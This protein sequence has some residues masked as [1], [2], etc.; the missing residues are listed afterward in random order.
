MKIKKSNVHHI[1]ELNG[2]QKGILFDSL[3]HE[4]FS[5]YNTQIVLEINGVLKVGLFE[6]SLIKAQELNDVLRSVFDWEKTSK[7][8]QIILK[9]TTLDY[10]FISNSEVAD[11]CI[12]SFLD[13]DRKL[14][15][16]LNRSCPFRIRLIQRTKSNYLFIITHHTI[17]YDGWSNG[18]FL[19][20]I[21]STYYRLKNTKEAYVQASKIHYN[22]YIDKIKQELYKNSDQFWKKYLE[23]Y[24]PGIFSQSTPEGNEKETGQEKIKLPIDNLSDFCK[25]EQLT[26]ASLIYTAYG[27]LLQ[28]YLN[29]DD[30]ILGTPVSNRN[31]FIEGFNEVMGNFV[32]TLPLRVHSLSDEL[33]INII[34]RIDKELIDRNAYNHSSLHE[35]KTMMQLGA[36]NNFFNSILAIEN[37]PVEETAINKNEEFKVSVHSTYESI[38]APLYQ[39]YC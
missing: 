12:S 19:K 14:S 34:K 24:V 26:K 4:D 11:I 22:A 36:E 10:K 23:E 17:L 13:E 8:L 31:P 3:K 25:K 18:I 32:N 33:I 15:F 29:S 27:L 2:L 1:L 30:V 28:K 35:V 39:S 9:K 6:K 37:Y 21:F 20:D 16:D 38:E 7:P 5:L